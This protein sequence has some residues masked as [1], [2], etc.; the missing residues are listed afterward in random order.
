MSGRTARERHGAPSALDDLELVLALGDEP[1]LLAIADALVATRTPEPGAAR[2]PRARRGAAAAGA[3]LAGVVAAGLMLLVGAPWRGAPTLAERALAAVG[4]APVLHVALEEPGPPL[5]DLA[6]GAEVPRTLRTEVW[7]DA[8]RSLKRTVTTLDGQV[9]D[10]LLET[11]GGSWTRGGPVYTCAWIAA[12]PVE[13]TR[14]GVSCS[15]DGE[16]G[17]APRRVP[18]PPP[19]LDPALSELA[20]RFRSALAGGAVRESGR[21]VIDGRE[22][23]WLRVPS[24]QAFERVALD[25]DTFDPVAL[26]RAGGGRARVAVSESL[27]ASAARF[28]RPAEDA[29]R[30]GGAVAASSVIDAGEAPSVVEGAVWLGRRW[31][32][33]ALVSVERQE[34]TVAVDGRSERVPVVRLS[35]APIGPDGEPARSPRL[36]LYASP[37]CVVGVGWSCSARDPGA[38]GL[39]GAPFGLDGPLAIGLLRSGAAYVSIWAGDDAP[40]LVEA[41]RALTPIPAGAG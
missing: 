8:N 40:G 30:T 16:N 11:P 22:V 1:E 12:H 24:A 17:T 35:Y 19:A 13:A 15:A 33:L 14:A 28:P 36:D 41:A 39:L 21:G 3:V 29:A 20:D 32:G 26:E 6:T 31:N 9:L 4:N 25:A 37:R 5:V 2:R 34:R 18:E 10:E 23:V 38:P 27:P 7:F